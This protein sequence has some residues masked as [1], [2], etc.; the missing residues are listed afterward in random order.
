MDFIS[1]Y[2]QNV[3]D[4]DELGCP[5]MKKLQNHFV[6]SC[7]SHNK[8]EP[9][10]LNEKFW[11]CTK[12]KSASLYQWLEKCKYENT[13]GDQLDVSTVNCS[14]ERLHVS[15]SKYYSFGNFEQRRVYWNCFLQSFE[16]RRDP[17]VF[18][19][20]L[21][22]KVFVWC[23]WRRNFGWNMSAESESRQTVI[24]YEEENTTP[25]LS[26][27]ECPCPI[28]IHTGFSKLPKGVKQI[29]KRKKVDTI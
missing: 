15:S 24:H 11:H 1:N 20:V 5:A 25:Q 21:L 13:G 16:K 12:I 7:F 26:Q 2:L 9:W 19:R 22:T 10:K 3:W 18:I 4:L 17:F 8:S 14:F 27:H 23:C 28:E 6:I 29:V